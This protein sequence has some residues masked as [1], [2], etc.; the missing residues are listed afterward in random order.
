MV[1]KYV[2]IRNVLQLN[3]SVKM[4]QYERV[5]RQAFRSVS[6]VKNLLKKHMVNK[7]DGSAYFQ[8]F[9]KFFFHMK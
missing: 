1:M 7:Y 6:N 8:S 4:L 5:Y 2:N 9:L 3:A